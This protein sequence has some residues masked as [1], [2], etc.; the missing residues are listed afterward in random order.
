ML[1]QSVILRLTETESTS[2]VGSLAH[3]HTLNHQ[4]HQN[5]LWRFAD[6]GPEHD[7]W[8]SAVLEELTAIKDTGTWELVD[9]SPS[10]HNIIGCRFVLQKKCG[11]DSE[12]MKYKAHLVAQGF[13]Q[14]EGIDYLETFA[15]VVKSASLCIF[16]TICAQHSWKI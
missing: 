15:P 11:P 2:R 16:L 5:Q 3:F 12:V 7:K 1:F 8:H 6:A 10:I 13:S 4:N 9:C 14:Q